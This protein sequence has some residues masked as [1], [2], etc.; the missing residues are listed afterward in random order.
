MGR[1]E[2]KQYLDSRFYNGQRYVEWSNATLDDLRGSVEFS[3][4]LRSTSHGT[5]AERR[6][7]IAVLRPEVQRRSPRLAGAFDEWADG[8]R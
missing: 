6:E 3:L 1:S 5:D 7:Q 8:L 2:R 4:S